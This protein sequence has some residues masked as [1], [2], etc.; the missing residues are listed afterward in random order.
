MPLYA[1]AP[2][3]SIKT[4]RVWRNAVRVCAP[5]KITIP[6]MRIS[7]LFVP[8]PGDVDIGTWHHKPH[9]PLACSARWG[10]RHRDFESDYVAI[11]KRPAVPE[12]FTARGHDGARKRRPVKP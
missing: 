4:D 8:D 9:A 6:T 3:F 1:A 5:K 12:A 11:K 2:D 7:I 10:W